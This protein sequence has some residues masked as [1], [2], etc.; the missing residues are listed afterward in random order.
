MAQYSVL[1]AANIRAYATIVVEAE[2]ED[3]A[4]HRAEDIT[5]AQRIWYEPEMAGVTF[6]PN[7]DCIEDF[8]V[9]DDPELID[10]RAEV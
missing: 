6:E 2:D 9:A 8:A 1:I 4:Y 10:E 7:F 5:W 3:A